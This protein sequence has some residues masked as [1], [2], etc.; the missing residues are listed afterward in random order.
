MKRQFVVIVVCSM[1][2]SV[3][4]FAAK[5]GSTATKPNSFSLSKNVVKKNLPVK[6]NKKTIITK[7]QICSCFYVGATFPGCIG[8]YSGE[9]C[10]DNQSQIDGAVAFLQDLLWWMCVIELLG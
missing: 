3:C 7:D 8:S 6:R 1:L 4:S 9:V 10:A 5:V 2:M